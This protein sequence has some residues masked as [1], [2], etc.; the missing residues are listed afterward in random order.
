MGRIYVVPVEMG[1]GAMIYIVSFI[2][3]LVFFFFLGSTAF[4]ELCLPSQLVAMYFVLVL[5]LSI[6]HSS[7]V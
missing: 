4:G 7:F 2:Y 5:S 1:S 6:Y 3:S